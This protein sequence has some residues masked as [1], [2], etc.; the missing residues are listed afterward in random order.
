MH[1]IF[2]FFRPWQLLPEPV[3]LAEMSFVSVII[4]TYNR[5]LPLERAVAS[6]VQQSY[7]DW[8]L[9]VIDDGSTDQTPEW[10]HAHPLFS[11]TNPKGRVIRTENQGVS[12]ARNLGIE[13]AQGEWIALLDSDDEWHVDK[14]KTQLDY[15]ASHPHQPLIHGEEIWVRNG[16]RVNQCKHHQKYGGRVFAACVPLCTIS[17]STVIIQRGLFTELGA[18]NEEFPVC[19]DYEMWLRFTCCHEVGLVTT[20]VVTKYGG[21]ADQL[22]HRYK[23][24][25]YWRVIALRAHLKNPLISESERQLVKRTMVD[26]CKI[27]LRGYEK[28]NNKANYDQVAALLRQAEETC[29]ALGASD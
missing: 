7:S 10:L 14:L 16:V 3:R 15:A 6:V 1:K 19:E 21:H 18:F 24:M 28:H 2:G 26:K 27:L 12:R 5:R 23:A 25:D 13:A 20:P 17:P 11:G 9:I 8:E 29:L 22:S 4:P